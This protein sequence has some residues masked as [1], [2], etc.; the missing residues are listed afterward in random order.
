MA[1]LGLLLRHQVRNIRSD[2]W[3]ALPV[4]ITPYQHSPDNK[5]P[6]ADLHNINVYV[7]YSEDK[8]EEPNLAYKIYVRTPYPDMTKLLMMTRRCCG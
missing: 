3:M 1:V 8:V 6:G 4:P 2:D 7:Q 5:K